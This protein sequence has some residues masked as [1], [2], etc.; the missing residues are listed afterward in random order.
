MA[1][2]GSAASDLDKVRRHERILLDLG[3]LA[4]G[5]FELEHLLGQAVTLVARA[6]EINHVKVLRYRREQGDLLTIA[7]IGWKP[8][9]VG[10]TTFA[11]DLASPPGRAYRTGQP[12][13][14]P[15]IANAEEFRASK[16]LAEHDIVSLLNV[17]I[18]IDR[19]AWG[20]LEVDSAVPR[21][22]SADTVVFLQTAAI[23][24]A[25]AI[26]RL[27]TADAYAAAVAHTAAE[28]Q[29][30][31]VV[32]TEMQHRVKNY[33]Q[34]ILAMLT[35][36]RPRLPTDTGR[37]V[38]DRVAERILAVSL[39]HDQLSPT[40]DMREVNLPTYL[41]AICTAVDVQVERVAID[42]QADELDLGV[43]KAVPLGLIV[44]ELVTNSIKHAF[45]GGGGAITVSVRTGSNHGA[46]E[47]TVAD[48]GRGVDPAKP[49]GS[50]M[51]LIRALARQI[52]GEVR[53]QSSA[54]GTQTVV[55]FPIT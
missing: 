31:A 26:Q 53:Q 6:V 45:D 20:V 25:G 40:Q 5:R 36:E 50:G 16:T 42:V 34:L 4:T 19:A 7:G 33:F 52:G 30:H 14:I 1:R 54:K 39:A 8:G 29:R 27:Q 43:D 12:V 21:D 22:F 41:R 55:S 17:P 38:I 47:L 37:S 32:L 49:G 2:T 28:A 35:V 23:I 10:H 48:N 18:L 9:T 13:I 51:T 46:A 15:D 11:V 3:Q 44:N 24:L